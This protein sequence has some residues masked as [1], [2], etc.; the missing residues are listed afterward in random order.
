MGN[1]RNARRP[2]HEARPISME[3]GTDGVLWYSEGFDLTQFW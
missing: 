2:S 3:D 1:V